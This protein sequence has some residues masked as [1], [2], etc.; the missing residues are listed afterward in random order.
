LSQPASASEATTALMAVIVKSL[1][2]MI[3]SPLTRA[4]WI[5]PE[6]EG[7]PPAEARPKEVTQR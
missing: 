7:L 3:G 6:T 1:E 4:A 5:W 2:F